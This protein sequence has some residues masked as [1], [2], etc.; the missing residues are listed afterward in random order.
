MPILRQKGVCMKNYLKALVMILLLFSFSGCSA[1][2]SKKEPRLRYTRTNTDYAYQDHVLEDLFDA[3]DLVIIGTV[4][5]GNLT[6]VKE[7]ASDQPVTEEDDILAEIMISGLFKGDS[8]ESVQVKQKYGDAFYIT[9]GYLKYSSSYLLFLK[10]DG[11][12]YTLLSPE[13]RY[14]L[15]DGAFNP[16]PRSSRLGDIQTPEELTAFLDNVSLS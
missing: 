10:K 7:I 5:N 3:S 11:S 12:K 2:T 1:D 13:C 4:T 9:N 16:V 6:G 14:E 8:E 15:T